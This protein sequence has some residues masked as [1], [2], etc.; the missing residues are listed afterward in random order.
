MTPVEILKR[1]ID[2]KRQYIELIQAE[3]EELHDL[4][5]EEEYIEELTG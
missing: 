5:V 3:I 4:V 2:L 1:K